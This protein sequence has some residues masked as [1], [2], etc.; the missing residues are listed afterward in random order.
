MGKVKLDD[1]EKIGKDAF[2]SDI[3]CSYCIHD[4]TVVKGYCDHCYRSHYVMFKGK[5][6]IFIE[7]N[8]P[9]ES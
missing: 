8:Q 6:C 1:D 2:R 9:K 4:G 7:K 3:V 5:K